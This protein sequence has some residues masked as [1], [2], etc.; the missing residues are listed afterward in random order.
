MN[1]AVR[2]AGW[3]GYSLGGIVLLSYASNFAT[4]R[5]S[6]RNLTERKCAF[7]T[8]TTS[9]IVTAICFLLVVALWAMGGNNVTSND[10]SAILYVVG[11]YIFMTGAIAWPWVLDA[12][13]TT[14]AELAALW[15]TAIGSIIMFSATLYQI[16][17]LP[18]TAYIMFHHVLVDGM[19]W[20]RYGRKMEQSFNDVNQLI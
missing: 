18:F 3:V 8:W 7:A 2:I 19:W 11:L 20:P 17:A 6:A 4:I 13:E 16:M 12:E 1:P 14:C 10:D 15:I 9:A 5:R